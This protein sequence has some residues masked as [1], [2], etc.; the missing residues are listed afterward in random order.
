VERSFQLG[1]GAPLAAP[2]ERERQHAVLANRVG[3]RRP[4]AVGESVAI[5][6]VEDRPPHHRAADT[7]AEAR[8]QIVSADAGALVDDDHDED[9][10]GV[11]DGTKPLAELHV[12]E[13]I[14]LAEG[15]LGLGEACVSRRVAW[16]EPTQ[17]D[18]VRIGSR[19]IAMHPDLSDR[20]LCVSRSGHEDSDRQPKAQSPEPKASELCSCHRTFVATVASL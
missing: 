17:T 2:R 5:G 6:V 12:V 16:L 20:L 13:A 7:R 3:E 10:R 1:A 18:D 14:A 11:V 4:D 9:V 8:R 15:L 19:V